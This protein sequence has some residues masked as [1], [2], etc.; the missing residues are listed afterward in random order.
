MSEWNQ[1][2][3]D[4]LDTVVDTAT[5]KIVRPAHR[6]A[7]V[8]VYGIVVATLLLIVLFFLFIA[9]FRATSIALPVYGSYLVWGGIFLT[10]GTLLWAKK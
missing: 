5:N 8:S 6:L 9:A 4:T 2:V 10:I 3:L 1:T 7:R